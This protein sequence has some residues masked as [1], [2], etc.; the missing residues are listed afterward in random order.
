[1]KKSYLL[2]IGFLLTSTAVFSQQI[3]VSGL[4]SSSTL[5][6]FKDNWG[7]DVG[8]NHF[9]NNNRLGVSFRYYA[10]NTEYD[11]IYTSDADGV[12]KEITEHDPQNR[13]IAINLIYSYSLIKNE[14]SNLYLGC[15]VGLNYF[16]LQEKVN[17]TAN[18]FMSE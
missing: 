4:Y 15:N 13:R 1:M 16:K 6:T 11:D 18:G 5:N 2:L 14:K 17:Q 12:S 3:D 10:Y 7:F 8:Y 9:I